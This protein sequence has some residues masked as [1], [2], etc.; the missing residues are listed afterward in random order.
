MSSTRVRRPRREVAESRERILTTAE[1]FFT[2][3]GVDASLHRL[4]QEAGVGVATLFRRFPSRDELV[5]ALYDRM[6]ARVDDLVARIA[7]EREPGW[8]SLVA[9][10]EGSVEL[11][12]A[13]P[14]LPDVMKRMVEI[15]PDYRPGDRWIE[16]LLRDVRIAQ[17]TGDLRPDATGYDL[18]IVPSAI[19]GLVHLQEPVRSVLASRLVRIVLGGL[20][21]GER[22]PLGDAPRFETAEYH[23]SVHGMSEAKAP[24]TQVPRRSGNDAGR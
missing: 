6:V 9:Y 19:G 2:E 21:T 23:R 14:L 3:N 8:D 4:A 7:R 10:V 13:S 20:K 18:A 1:R 11:M 17:D 12:F 15:D 16:P 24:T 22:T 5:R